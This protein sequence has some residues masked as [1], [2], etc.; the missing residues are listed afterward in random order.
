MSEP[1]PFSHVGNIIPIYP[2]LYI[3]QGLSLP[4]SQKR[5]SERE[6]EEELHDGMHRQSYPMPLLL[7]NF[8]KAQTF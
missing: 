3:V 5:E 7:T 4:V 8:L 1:F 6:E 2:G